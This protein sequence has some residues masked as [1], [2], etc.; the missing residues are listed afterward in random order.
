MVPQAQADSDALCEGSAILCD[1]N[2]EDIIIAAEA[3]GRLAAQ[4]LA[5][6]CDASELARS[7]EVEVDVGPA[8][9]PVA[10]WLICTQRAIRS[11]DGTALVTI[12]LEGA[13]IAPAASADRKSRSLLVRQAYSAAYCTVLAEEAGVVTE[14]RVIAETS[15]P[16]DLPAP[17]PPSDPHEQA[18]ALDK[19]Y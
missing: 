2:W 14:R 7:G 11:D 8:G 1:G 17:R 19:S 16:A 10:G 13:D 18:R 12:D 5:L 15:V 9:S 4:E 6:R 3:A